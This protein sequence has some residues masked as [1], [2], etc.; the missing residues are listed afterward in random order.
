M[1]KIPTILGSDEMLDKA[2]RRVKKVRV[3]DQ[4]GLKRSKAEAVGKVNSLVN[5]LAAQLNKY[6]KAFPSIDRLHPFERELIDV[7]VGVD[8]LKHSLGA[9]DWARKTMEGIKREERDA[10]KKAGGADEVGKRQNAVFGRVSSV[11]DKVAG[12]LEF[13]KGARHKLKSIPD[14]RPDEPIVVI[15]GA[16]N[17]GKSLIVRQISSGK[18]EIASYPFTTKNVSLGHM[19]VKRR[20]VQV[21]DTPGLLDRPLE[22]R[23]P[24]ELQAVAALQHLEGVFV[25]V[26]DPSETCGYSLDSQRNLLKELK[27]SFPETEFIIVSN[28]SDLQASAEGIGVSAKTGAGIGHLLSAIE[29]LI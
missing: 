2:F 20:R 16:P 29:G 6:V 26:F 27:M 11:M 8:R 7:V 4:R 13:L 9:L 23:N 15:A 3:T 24:I 18:P 21:M 1:K 28:K 10:I 17:V 25:F 19:M 12:D 22:E 14:I 5:T